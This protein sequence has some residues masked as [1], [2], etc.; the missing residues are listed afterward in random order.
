MKYFTNAVAELRELPIR[1]SVKV[2]TLPLYTIVE[3]DGES[4]AGWLRVTFGDKAGWVVDTLVEPYR[5]TLPRNCVKIDNQTPDPYDFE[6]FIIMNGIKQTNLC[7]ELS[8]CY[9]LGLDLTELMQAWQIKAPSLWNRIKGGGRFSGTNFQDLDIICDLFN[10][11]AK[12]LEAHMTDPYLKRARYT[13]AS[14]AEAC[15]TGWL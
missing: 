1:T 10:V 8:I 13:P 5:E 6:Q 4:H 11:D 9:A 7:G 14:L 3:H 12:P 15:E 2:A